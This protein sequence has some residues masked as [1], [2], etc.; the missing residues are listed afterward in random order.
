MTT[1]AALSAAEWQENAAA[2]QDIVVNAGTDRTVCVNHQLLLSSLNASITG[3]ASDG[4]WVRIGDGLFQ[5]GNLTSVRFLQAIQNNIIYVPGN[6]DKN[7]NL[8][9]ELLLVS[10]PGNP[11]PTPAKED[12]VRI[13]FQ[14][15]PP[16]FCN[17]NINISLNENCTQIVDASM[18][19]SNPLPPLS[20]YIVTLYDAAGKIILNNTLT[21]DH[22][23]KEITYKL[24][25]Q[26]TAN[27]CWGK[28]IVQDYFPPVFACRNDTILCTKASN[29]ASVGFPLPLGARIDTLISN[30]YTVSNWDLCSKVTLEYKDEV[31]KAN[32]TK[33]EDKTIIRRWKATDAKGNSSSCDQRIVIKRIP[34]SAVIFPPHYDGKDKPAF[35]C[36]DRFP[37]FSNGHPSTDTTGVP[38]VGFCGNLQFNMTDVRFDL[39]GKSFKIARSWFVID[40]CTS[41][42]IPRNQIILVR[43]SKGPEM[44]CSDTLQL[45][46]GAYFCHTNLV[47][48][49]NLIKIEDCN[50]YSIQY[51]LT[52][53]SGFVANQFIKFQQQKYY[54]D[55]LPVG[56][57]NL[58]YIATDECNNSTICSTVVDVKDNIAPSVVC[59]QTTKI[60]LDGTGRG[61]A[62]AFTFDDGSTDNCSIAS[63]K[64]RKMSDKCGFGTTFGDYVDFCC[65]EIGT[66]V[67]VA[68]EVTDVYGNKNICMVEVL[69]E[70]KLK[71]VISCPPNITL[72]CTDNYDLKNLDIF[73]RVV[74]KSSDIKDIKIFNYYHNGF[75]GK[76]GLAS[77]NC[78]VTVSSSYV[79]D[80]KCFTGTIIRKFIAKDPTGLK[81]SCIQTITILNP[82]PFD[83]NDTL[84]LKWPP[85]YVS[86]G[87]KSSAIGPEITGKPLFTNTSCGTIAASYDDLPFYIADG[88]CVKII[89]TWTV[90]DWCQFTD[91]NQKGKW[92]PYV[93]LIK[94]HNT[95]KPIF[96]SVCKDTLICSFDNKCKSGWVQISQ[97]AKDSCT[98]VENLVWKYEIDTNNNGT[99][100]SIGNKNDFAG[101]LPLGKHK[102]IWTVEDQCGNFNSCSL[103]ITILDC[104]KPSPYCLTSVTTSFM[105]TAGNVEIW[106]R[107]FDNGST[108]NCTE[109]SDLWFTF[110]GDIPVDSLKT[111]QHYFKGKGLVSNEAEYRSG[112][113]QKWIPATKSSGKYFDCKN[114][115]NGKSAKIPLS[116][117]ITDLAGNQD[118]C[119]VE[120]II[121][122][123]ANLCPDLITEAIVSGKIVT[124]NNKVP[125]NTEIRYETVENLASKSINNATGEYVMDKLPLGKEYIISP[126]LNSD[127][128]EGV[129]TFDL[130]MIQRHILGLSTFDNQ[131]K[132]LAADINSSSSVTAGDLVELRKLIL[133]ITDK[134]PKEL[135]SWVFVRKSEGFPEANFPFKYINKIQTGILTSDQKGADFVAVKIGDVNLSAFNLTNEVIENR[136]S[137]VEYFNVN[138]DIE[139]LREQKVLTFRAANNTQLDGFQFFMQ[140]PKAYNCIEKSEKDLAGQFSDYET[141]IKEDRLSSLAYHSRTIALNKGD[142][143]AS[144][145]I[146]DEMDISKL[147]ENISRSSEVYIGN[148]QMRVNYVFINKP[149]I[150]MSEYRLQTN[151]VSNILILNSENPISNTQLSYKI[152]NS[153]GVEVEAGNI[154]PSYNINIPLGDEL[155]PGIYF[156]HLK[157]ENFLQTLKFIRIR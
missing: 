142:L 16:L 59:D 30:R 69:V 135:T 56:M 84:Q 110:D 155:A 54:F 43:D 12:R 119:T 45:F 51:Q 104:K 114:L 93:Q 63:Y 98:S 95:D 65:S 3:D 107:D 133:G 60:S 76:D 31:I 58:D 87:C 102:F 33:D 4:L 99:I 112:L 117:T 83:G 2:P 57:Y 86:D 151:P 17:S 73:G 94:L 42:S 40:W 48:I 47:P 66:I 14:N 97:S 153:K 46:A 136:N 101:E 157:H 137:N 89:R 106:A 10:D 68:F 74:T 109:I 23:D 100:D 154:H 146:T 80:I 1:F 19:Q 143:M 29:P 67:M 147:R 118:F 9:Y 77:D 116:M 130:I 88:A 144:F 132:I 6:A 62:M 24:G 150:P 61:R 138:V 103:L 115:P 28:F 148:K 128:L 124:E 105:Q 96:T 127:P 49:P 72:T 39:C 141:Y 129:S 25:H 121:Q 20:N 120:L 122:D 38:N 92:G 53:K 44:M 123:N 125:L 111:V 152:I 145:D 21:R 55:E 37:V 70:D 81:D 32:C 149:T 90:L 34:L 108:D 41:E 7:I 22:I 79:A 8:R 156:L 13:T 91:N 35:E 140:Y 131:Y 11:N 85:N 52:D 71:P 139:V 126:Y 64:V 134:L 18:L 113:A 50:K 5:P 75:V 82:K 78:S 36:G 15:A 27:F 26:C